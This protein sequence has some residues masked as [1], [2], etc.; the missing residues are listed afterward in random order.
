MSVYT[1]CPYCGHRMR[2]RITCNA[3][4]D[5]PRLDPWFPTVS[6]PTVDAVS[7]TNGKAG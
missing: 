5:L 4:R 7:A 1:R 2:G 3:C 6:S